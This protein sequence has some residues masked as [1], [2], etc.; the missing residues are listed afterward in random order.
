VQQSVKLMLRNLDRRLL[1]FAFVMASIILVAGEARR[2]V[3]AEPQVARIVGLGATTCVQFNEDVRSNLAVQRDYLAWAQGYMSGILAGRPPGIDQGLDL[4]PP[5][6][7]MNNQL[8]FLRD[9]CAKSV[10]EN[11]SDAVEA[12]YKRL[13]LEGKT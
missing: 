6:F 2:E 10:S 11:F 7:D 9:Y 3:R 5:S 1:Q 4:N 13:R 8:H 12:L